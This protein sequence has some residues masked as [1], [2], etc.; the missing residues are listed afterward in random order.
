MTGREIGWRR[1]LAEMASALRELEARFDYYLVPLGQDALHQTEI[2]TLTGDGEV[3]EVYEG[4]TEYLVRLEVGLDPKIVATAMQNNRVTLE[5]L[6][7][8][9]L[10]PMIACMAA[11]NEALSIPIPR[12]FWPIEEA[13]EAAESLHH[14]ILGEWHF[15]TR[16]FPD[17]LTEVI[18]GKKHDTDETGAAGE[19]AD[20][21]APNHH[22][23][24]IR[25][26]TE[27]ALPGEPPEASLAR[28][29]CRMLWR[30][31]LSASAEEMIA[32]AN[33]EAG[34]GGDMGPVVLAG[35]GKVHPVMSHFPQVLHALP[36]QA[37]LL[38][39]P[40]MVWL[41]WPEATSW[42]RPSLGLPSAAAMTWA[43]VNPL[44]APEATFP[45]HIVGH[46]LGN[47]APS[48]YHHFYRAA[49]DM[50]ERKSRE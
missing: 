9:A 41:I 34:A 21:T 13:D 26:A 15:T 35:M 7:H 17:V 38:M 31:S 48:G 42:T 28:A 4:P 46:P 3:E 12:L 49:R 40:N 24:L 27:G 50:R 37:A 16:A 30:E 36:T 32:L 43:E 44:T 23:E 1:G 29:Q 6:M 47:K 19:P 25:L 18:D 39:P 45:R 11:G 14:I 33:H 5:E 20:Q 2:R 22:E 10:E 8:G